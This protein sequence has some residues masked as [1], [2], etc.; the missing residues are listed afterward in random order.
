MF[1]KSQPVVWLHQ[2]HLECV[3]NLTSY[4]LTTYYQIIYLRGWGLGLFIF[5]G[6]PSWLTGSWWISF[7]N[8]KK[9][10]TEQVHL[11]NDKARNSSSLGTKIVWS[12][13]HCWKW[14]R[15]R[16]LSLCSRFKLKEENDCGSSMGPVGIPF[17]VGLVVLIY[18]LVLTTND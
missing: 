14:N 2:C 13:Y 7:G 12:G 1:P 17:R 8:E 11:E 4:T 6:L 5:N 15:A 9:K 10:K 3:T 18:Q 16:H